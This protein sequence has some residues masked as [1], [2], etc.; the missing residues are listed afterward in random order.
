MLCGKTNMFY[1][2]IGNSFAM[3]VDVDR[4]YGFSP[5]AS[6]KSC[7]GETIVDIPFI[8][9]ILTGRKRLHGEREDV[10]G[11]GKIS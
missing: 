4:R 5:A 8:R 1:V 7:N 6:F 10:Q 9:I 11:T 3:L 2:K